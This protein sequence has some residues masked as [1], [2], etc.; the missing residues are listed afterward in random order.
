[1]HVYKFKF[2]LTS[3][4]D[5]FDMH[6]KRWLFPIINIGLQRAIKCVLTSG[7][8]SGFRWCWWMTRQIEK[9]ILYE[10]FIAWLNIVAPKNK[11]HNLN[12]IAAANK[13]HRAKC[14]VAKKLNW[15]CP[16][17]FP[18]KNAVGQKVPGHYITKL[19]A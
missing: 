15:K 1:M 3:T 16:K 11:P 10:P 12:I 18:C 8:L 2:W 17:W 5:S 13:Q 6:A 4:I 14:W 7:H 9:L 19:P